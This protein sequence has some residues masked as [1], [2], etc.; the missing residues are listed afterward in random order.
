MPNK[1]KRS[2]VKSCLPYVLAWRGDYLRACLLAYLPIASHLPHVPSASTATFLQSAKHG[3]HHTWYTCISWLMLCCTD[4]IEQFVDP[5]AAPE[6]CSFFSL[7][8]CSD[9][10]Q[11][12]VLHLLI[13]FLIC[14]KKATL[15]MVI[16]FIDSA[17]ERWLVLFLIQSYGITE[18]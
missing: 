10:I 18:V 11:L 4:H 12:I 6:P 13:P 8:T 1:R 16:S 2:L 7:I 3:F 5:P 9:C 17:F 15:A 14:A